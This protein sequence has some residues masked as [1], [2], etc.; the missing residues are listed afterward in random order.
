MRRLL[1][2]EGGFTV[3]ELVVAMGVS[4]VLLLAVLGLMDVV[5]RQSADVTRRVDANQRGR[6]AMERV[7]QTLRS[8]VCRGT[9]ET[10][11][12]ALVAGTGT[13][14]TLHRDFTDNAVKFDQA[15]VRLPP[16]PPELVVLTVAGGVLTE[17]VYINTGTVEAP[18]YPAT[19]NRRTRLAEGVVQDGTTPPFRYFQYD[20]TRTPPTPTVPVAT[21]NAT[22]AERVARI[23]VRFVTR[24]AQ[25][26]TT[27]RHALVLE[28]EVLVR[29]VDPH[30]AD[31]APQCA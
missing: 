9:G 5:V 4:M 15:G 10:S 3:A 6:L 28:D 18:K 29:T 14:I 26:T 20:K 22:T 7:T 12:P 24:P 30:A 11:D 19:P 16:T 31:P 21:I 27:T 13:S 2:Q 23:V 1:R 8:Q 25:A 17:D